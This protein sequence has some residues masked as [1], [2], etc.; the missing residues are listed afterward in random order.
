M[1]QSGFTP[2]LTYGSTT[3]GAVPLAANLTTTTNGVELAINAA[4]GILFY[5]DNGAVVQKIGYKVVP[6]TAGGTGATTVSGAQTNLQ[7]DPAGTAV[8]M[9]IALG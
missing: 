2:I 4:D 9:A 8:A 1:A 3:P 7:V 5:K 6:I